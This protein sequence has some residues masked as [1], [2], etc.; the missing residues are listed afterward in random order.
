MKNEQMIRRFR[1]EREKFERSGMFFILFRTATAGL[2]GLFC[3]GNA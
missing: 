2:E 3:S 1:I